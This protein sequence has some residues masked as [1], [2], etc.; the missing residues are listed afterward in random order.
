MF[1]IEKIKKNYSCNEELQ[2][3][4]KYL[5]RYDQ[6]IKKIIKNFKH[7]NSYIFN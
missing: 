3:I 4:E 2:L 1:L 5:N 6:T 7:Y